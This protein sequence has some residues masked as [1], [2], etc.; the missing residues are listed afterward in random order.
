MNLQSPTFIGADNG[1]YC[2]ITERT[3]R[4]EVT[5]EVFIVGKSGKI[6]GYV[7]QVSSYMIQLRGAY[8]VDVVSDYIGKMSDR[9]KKEFILDKSTLQI[10]LSYEEV[11]EI[12]WK[13]SQWDNF[14]QFYIER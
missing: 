13:D 10:K 12:I 4:G 5:L 14:K 9:I 3:F 8:L 1:I 7:S 11:S 2:I 6:N